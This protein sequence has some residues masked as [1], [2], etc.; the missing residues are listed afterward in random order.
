MDDSVDSLVRPWSLAH[1][2]QVDTL[3]ASASTAGPLLPD[4]LRVALQ[5]SQA[6]WQR[7]LAAEGWG[8]T[9]QEFDS[10]KFD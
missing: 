4:E 5:E 9:D 6:W 8:T 10:R 3:R 1:P 7:Q 2:D